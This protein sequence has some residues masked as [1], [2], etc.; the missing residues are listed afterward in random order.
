[1]KKKNV[2]VTTDATASSAVTQM[3]DVTSVEITEEY[4]IVKADN[5]TIKTKT[6]FLTSRVISVEEQENC[7]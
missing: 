5:G 6:T 4:T 2:T 3:A 1:M 7:D